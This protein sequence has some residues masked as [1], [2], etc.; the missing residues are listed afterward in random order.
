MQILKNSK[1]K[2]NIFVRIIFIFRYYFLKVALSDKRNSIIH[3]VIE[4]ILN[5]ILF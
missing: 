3:N 1:N 2:Q 5:N 4:T